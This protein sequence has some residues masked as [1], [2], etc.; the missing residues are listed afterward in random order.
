MLFIANP[1]T[2]VDLGNY[3]TSTVELIAVDYF[4]KK[5]LPQM[6]HRVLTTSLPPHPGLML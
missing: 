6:F 4:H 5:D 3:Q 1:T 2:E